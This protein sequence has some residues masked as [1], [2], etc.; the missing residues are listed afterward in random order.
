MASCWEYGETSQGRAAQ[1]A[2][3]SCTGC[4]GVLCQHCK[5][6]PGFRLLHFKHIYFDLAKGGGK[7]KRITEVKLFSNLNKVLSVLK[8]ESL[9]SLGKLW[10]SVQVS[11]G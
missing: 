6:S 8:K 4:L 5:A 10:V 1:H 11:S 9:I 3:P 7:K 2:G